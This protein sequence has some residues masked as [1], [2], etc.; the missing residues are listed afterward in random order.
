M[1]PK[2]HMYTQRGFGMAISM[3]AQWRGLWLEPFFSGFHFTVDIACDAALEGRSSCTQ[4]NMRMT[5]EVSDT[6]C[7]P[8]CPYLARLEDPHAL[9][10]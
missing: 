9:R 4:E 2:N 8:P 10:E 7:W 3:K 5:S 1:N 6:F